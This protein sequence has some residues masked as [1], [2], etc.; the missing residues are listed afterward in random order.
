VRS[1]TQDP[2][3]PLTIRPLPY[4]QVLR[5]ARHREATETFQAEY[6][7]RTGIAATMSRGVW[8]TRLRRTRDRGLARVHLRHILTAVGLNV[9]RLGEWFLENSRAKTRITPC[10]RL[11]ADTTAA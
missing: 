5:V 3:R 11:M 1:K 4:D 2:R 10:A 8:G 9:L 7:R 6:A